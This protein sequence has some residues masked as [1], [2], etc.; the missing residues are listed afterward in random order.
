MATK[1]RFVRGII[2]FGMDSSKL[3]SIAS[4]HKR[5][6]PSRCVIFFMKEVRCIGQRYLLVNESG[7][8]NLGLSFLR[9][10]LMSSDV[11]STF[12]RDYSSEG[13]VDLSSVVTVTYTVSSCIGRPATLGT[14]FVLRSICVYT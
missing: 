6:T 10:Q 7:V 14:K 3:N 5:V 11:L 8:T 13:V 1:A 4:F 9:G 2:L 12:M